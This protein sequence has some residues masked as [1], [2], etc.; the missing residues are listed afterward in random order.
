M[1][2]HMVC[3][4]MHGLA[5]M[6]TVPLSALNADFPQAMDSHQIHLQSSL[7]FC[8]TSGLVHQS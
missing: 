3:M 4:Q 8:Q 6:R 7:L 1:Y 2:M 5:L